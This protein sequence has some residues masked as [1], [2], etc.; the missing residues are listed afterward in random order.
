MVSCGKR[1]SL[2]VAGPQNTAAASH[3]PAAASATD[4]S[5]IDVECMVAPCFLIV[6]R[7]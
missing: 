5:K 3:P 2:P 4:E 1:G 7:G 6:A